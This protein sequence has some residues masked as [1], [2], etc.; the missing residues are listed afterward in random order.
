MDANVLQLDLILSSSSFSSSFRFGAVHPITHTLK[1]SSRVWRWIGGHIGYAMVFVYEVF[2][3]MA[4]NLIH[5]YHTTI[6]ELMSAQGFEYIFLLKFS[7]TFQATLNWNDICFIFV[8][9]VS[10]MDMFCS[11]IF[12]QTLENKIRRSFLNLPGFF[13]GKW[14]ISKLWF[15]WPQCL[16][17]LNIYFLNFNLVHSLYRWKIFYIRFRFL[18]LCLLWYESKSCLQKN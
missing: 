12:A 2:I 8:N 15:S 13:T 4:S 9:P 11:K 5:W 7:N 14:F 3:L 16:T 17:G 10:D 18:S 1:H 6:S